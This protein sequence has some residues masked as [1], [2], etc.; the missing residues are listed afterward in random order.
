MY[1]RILKYFLLQEYRLLE[2]QEQ[3]GFRAEN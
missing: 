2:T 3:A 1:G